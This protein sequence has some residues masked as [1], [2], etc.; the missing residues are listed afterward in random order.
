MILFSMTFTIDSRE[1]GQGFR[2][3]VYRLAI[4]VVIMDDAL[5]SPQSPASNL[6]TVS[7]LKVGFQ[8]SLVV[9]STI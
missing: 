2:P 9:S 1:D 4:V 5:S 3:L 6:K 8:T 7:S